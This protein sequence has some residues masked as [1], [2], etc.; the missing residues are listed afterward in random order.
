MGRATLRDCLWPGQI[1]EDG[2]IA[3]VIA[4]ARKA[5]GDLGDERRYIETV[6]KFGYRF[7]AEVLEE[8]E[9]PPVEDTALE[10]APARNWKWSALAV[11]AI[12]LVAGAW[13]ALNR[14]PKVESL[15]ITPFQVI[16]QSPEPGIL[17]LGLQDSLAMELSSFSGFSVIKSGEMPE[18]VAESGRRH[19]ARFVLTGTVESNSERIHVNAR[20]L[21]STNGQTVWVRGFDETM[22]DIYKVQLR[23]AAMTVAEVIPSLPVADRGLLERHHPT[24]GAAFRYYLLGRYFWNK[25]DQNGEGYRLAFE[26][27]QKS[28]E[29]DPNYAPAYIGIADTYL[30]GSPPGTDLLAKALPPARA[31]L[32]K[33]VQFDPTLGEARLSPR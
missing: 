7:V 28:I 29:A 9:A 16:G 27:F 12:V 26:M 17:R 31:A 11:A 14:P 8:P 21:R 3:R 6:P 4:D 18:D 33:A 5:L 32:E 1:V 10:T 25:R 13:L 24:N 20:L 2:T 19:H 30:I 22:N 15:L 23:L